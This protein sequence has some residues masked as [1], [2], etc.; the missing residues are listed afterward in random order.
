VNDFNYQRVGQSG[1]SF[2]PWTQEIAGSNPA[3]LTK[4]F[5]SRCSAVWL[6]HMPW[7]HGVAGSNPVTWT[8]RISY[9]GVGQ[10]G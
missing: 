5:L 3:P 10:S 9:R 4:N 6:A 1:L 8:K 2:L 7:E